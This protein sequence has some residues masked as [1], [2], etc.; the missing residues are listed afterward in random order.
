MLPCVTGRVDVKGVDFSYTSDKE[1]IKDLNINVSSAQRVA[2]VGPTGCGKTTMINLLMRFYDV[3]N[4][5]I[6]VDDTDIR[7]VTRRSLRG[8][9]GMVLQD[10]WLFAGTI[11]ENLRMA[12]PDASDEEVIAAAKET[13]AHG[14]IRRLEKGYDT[15]IGEDGEGLSIGQKQL[16]CITRVMLNIP[17]MLILDE[18][19]SSIDTRTEMKIQSA[20]EKL[21]KN[22]TSFIVAHRLPTIRNADMILVMKDGKIIE[23]GDHKTLMTANGFYKKLYEA[24]IG[25]NDTLILA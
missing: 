14:F 16:L 25:E 13:H 5:S 18:A 21:M 24:G 22:R 11:M 12:K 1:L 10:T 15:F 3:D 19:T 7:S 2:I 8:S 17:P 9:Y 4:G 6:C 20:F 23:Q